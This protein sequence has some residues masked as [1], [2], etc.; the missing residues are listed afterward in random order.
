MCYCYNYCRKAHLDDKS[1]GRGGGGYPLCALP[2]LFVCVH[3]VK[4]GCYHTIGVYVPLTGNFSI[5]G[6]VLHN[7]SRLH[8]RLFS[9][10]FKSFCILMYLMFAYFFCQIS[11]I[12]IGKDLVMRVPLGNLQHPTSTEFCFWWNV[13]PSPLSL[14][15]FNILHVVTEYSTQKR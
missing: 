10:S 6:I 13:P 3:A 11:V 4:G 5:F 14:Y 7:C 1:G 12:C 9:P 15:S 2:T 8:I